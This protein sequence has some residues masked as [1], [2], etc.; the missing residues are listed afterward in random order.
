M[1]NTIEILEN[2]N[3]IYL[4]N[5][6]EKIICGNTN[7]FLQFSF[8][9]NWSAVE[10][11]TAIFEVLGKKIIKEF[12]G[13]ICNIPCMPNASHFLLALT[14]SPNENESY[15]TNILRF[16][17]EKNAIN[18]EIQQL[19]PFINYYSKLQNVLNEIQSGN[20]S[21]RH[22]TTAEQSLTQV[23][24]SGNDNISGNKNFVGN[25]TFNEKKVSTLNDLPNTNYLINSSMIV[26]QRNHS[27]YSGLNTYCVDRWKLSDSIS[28]ATQNFKIRLLANPKVP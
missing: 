5:D 16:E 10:K 1:Y 19:D 20:F 13:N 4:K 15:A 21:V 14:C 18:E 22:A 25:L 28:F 17:L 24:L 7:Y 2:K 9:E 8:D 27:T 23:S 3:K 12:T 26:N 6:F 11:K